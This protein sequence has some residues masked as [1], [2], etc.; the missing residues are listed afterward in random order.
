MNAKIKLI[1]KDLKI[2]DPKLE[3]LKPEIE[4]AKSSNYSKYGTA[5]TEIETME[6]KL[7]ICLIWK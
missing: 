2:D 7:K 5:R 6:A 3:D 1:L 4:K